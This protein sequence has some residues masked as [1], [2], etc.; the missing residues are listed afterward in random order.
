[1]IMALVTLLTS[2]HQLQPPVELPEPDSV[3]GWLSADSLSAG[4]LSA[5]SLSVGSLSAGWL[6]VGW[7]S[8]EISVSPSLFSMR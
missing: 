2:A 4:S 3:E 6:S 8:A 7:L 5:S 1:M